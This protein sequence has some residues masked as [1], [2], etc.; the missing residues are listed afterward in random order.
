M[1]KLSFNNISYATGLDQKQY[2]DFL[3]FKDDQLVHN[4]YESFCKI[5][6]DDTFFFVNVAKVSLIVTI[7]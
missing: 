7:E 4:Y 2:S 1:N 6:S 5:Y 3:I